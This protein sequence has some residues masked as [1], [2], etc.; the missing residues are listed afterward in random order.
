M[1]GK[2]TLKTRDWKTWDLR[3]MESLTKYNI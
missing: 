3:S 2:G 1:D